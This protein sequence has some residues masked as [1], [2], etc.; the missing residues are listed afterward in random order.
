MSAYKEIQTI[1][2]SLTSLLNAQHGLFFTDDMLQIPES[3]IYHPA[4]V[5]MSG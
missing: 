4:N 3:Q 5:W 1:Y 2:R